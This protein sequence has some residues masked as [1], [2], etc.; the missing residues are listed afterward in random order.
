MM[1]APRGGLAPGRNSGET[2]ESRRETRLIDSMGNSIWR[3]T[4]NTLTFAE[5]LVRELLY[6]AVNTWASAPAI[7]RASAHYARLSR[8]QVNRATRSVETHL[9]RLK[10]SLE[11]QNVTLESG[12]SVF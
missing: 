5:Q 8:V 1:E 9:V 4:A 6:C 12:S 10:F 3:I 2:S 11:S 7:G